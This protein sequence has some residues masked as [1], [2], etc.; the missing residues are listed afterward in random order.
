MNRER[1]PEERRVL[2]LAPTARDA[3]ASHKLLSAAGIECALCGGL[4]GLRAEMAIG[5]GVIILPE[6]VVLMDIEGALHDALRR[7]PVWSDLPVIVLSRAGAQSPAVDKALSTLGNVSLVERPVRISTLVS[8]IRAALRAR[9]HQYQ[10]R[11]LL[12]DEQEAR[13]EADAANRAKDHFLAVLSHELRT[14]LSPVVMSLAAVEADPGLP[15]SLRSD[16]RMIRRN[17]DLEVKLID[18]LLD[19]SRIT[20]G[21]LRLQRQS[22]GIHDLLRHV[23]QICADD[24]NVKQLTLSSDLSAR[25]DHVMADPARL[26]QVFWNLLKNSVRFT[27]RNGSIT[28]RTRNAAGGRLV[29]EVRDTGIGIAADLLPRVFDAFEQEH[30]TVAGQGGLGL[31]LAISK[32]LVDLHGGTIRVAS[33]GRNRGACF[34]VELIPAQGTEEQPGTAWTAPVIAPGKRPSLL[35]VED[36][37]DTAEVLARLLQ[38]SGY[39]VETAGSVA[40]ALKTAAAVPFDLLISDIGLP[41]ASG[42]ELMRQVRDRFGIPGIALSGYGMEEDIRKSQEAGFLDHIVK[43]V[44]VDQLKAAIQRAVN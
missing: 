38:S 34:T 18:D 19:M 7:Q 36:H 28:V 35:I 4:D 17:I 13:R 24:L 27:P 39:E 16:V 25:N 23:F 41:D 10:I 5:A 11:D 6:E 12:A 2:L 14:P 32:A 31:G 20:N 1:G 29:V 9:E 15:A 21:K 40:E 22:T 8:Q 37:A 44:N 3:Q 33:D 42:L 30:A 26:Q 43:P